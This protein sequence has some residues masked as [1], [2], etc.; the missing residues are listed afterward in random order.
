MNENLFFPVIQAHSTSTTG[1][2]KNTAQYTQLNV[3]VVSRDRHTSIA[4]RPASIIS[5]PYYGIHL[6]DECLRIAVAKITY[7]GEQLLDTAMARTQNRISFLPL[8]L[9]ASTYRR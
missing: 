4:A 6:T 7:I 1:M 8:L 5:V 9:S 2:V 3:T